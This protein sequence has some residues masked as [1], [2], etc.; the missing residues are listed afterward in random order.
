MVGNIA[1]AD[2]PG[3]L[4]LWRYLHARRN[5]ASVLSDQRPDALLLRCLTKE[6]IARGLL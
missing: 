4:R 6:L 5:S 2:S 1:L 3:L